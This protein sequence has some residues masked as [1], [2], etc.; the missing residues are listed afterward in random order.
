VVLADAAEMVELRERS[1]PRVGGS[2]TV[3]VGLEC[4]ESWLAESASVSSHHRCGQRALATPAHKDDHCSTLLLTGVLCESLLLC[5]EDAYST[6]EESICGAL[7]GTHMT[8]R[9][10]PT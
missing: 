7:V 1:I 8:F 4:L 10:S 5:A 2:G 9:S 6:V 3:V